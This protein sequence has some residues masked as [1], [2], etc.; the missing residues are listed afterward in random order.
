MAKK[1][2]IKRTTGRTI[3]LVPKISPTATS[4]RYGCGGNLKK[5]K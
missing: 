1:S 5:S 2:T 4:R 3:P